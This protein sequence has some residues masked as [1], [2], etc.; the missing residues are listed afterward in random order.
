MGAVIQL[1][2]LEAVSLRE[3]WP[4]EARNF[5]PWLAEDANLSLLSDAL[6]LHLELEA[7]EK[8]VGPFSADI[9]A[10]EAGTE[11]WVLIEN[12]VEPTDHKHLGQ[13]LTYAA[14]LDA[15]TIVWIAQAFREE[16]RAAIDFLNRATNEDFAF[17]GVQVELFRIGDSALAPSFTIVAKP[18]NW[19]KKAQAG[20][21]AAEESLG[22]SQALYREFWAAVIA[23]AASTYPDLAVRTPYKGNWQTAERLLSS[24]KLV[25]EANATFTQGRL[26]AEVYIGGL[27]AKAAFAKVIREKRALE[28]AF[29]SELAW[30][31][32]PG[33]Q[34]C[35]ISFYMPGEQKRENR[36]AWP[37]QARWLI[38]NVK[39]LADT[40]RPTLR[41]LDLAELEETEFDSLLG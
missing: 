27:L 23:Q 33:K 16:H 3:A 15:Q 26:R 36:A 21:Q 25:V 39:R 10:K 38:Q 19:S 37:G 12:Q 18:N 34:D 7:V 6:G 29:G 20:K 22:P 30:E 35:R 17:F 11:R 32:L 14:G 24:K 8:A 41:A 5:T 1:G 31:E 28:E 4:D 9:L 2:R 13:L 40:F